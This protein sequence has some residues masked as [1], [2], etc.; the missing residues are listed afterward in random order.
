MAGWARTW[1]GRSSF[2]GSL[3]LV[4]TLIPPAPSPGIPRLS[5]P[6]LPLPFALSGVLGQAN[7]AY[8]F[9]PAGEG[10]VATSPP[11]R[12]TARVEGLV[13][14][15]VHGAEYWTSELAAWGRG[16]TLAPLTAEA[17]YA[18]DNRV[19]VAAAGVIAWVQNGPAG[20]QQGWT[21]HQPP[22][23]E[24]LLTL[25]LRHQGTLRARPEADG[26][27]LQILHADGTLALRWSGLLAWD[28]RGQPLAAGL[29][30]EG[31][32]TRLWVDAREAIYP[33]TIDP[34]VQAARLNAAGASDGS[35]LGSAVAVSADGSTIVAGAPQ[36]GC[37]SESGAV[38]V[39]LR[40]NGGWA[41]T[42]TFAAKLTPPDGVA[43][44]Q[45]GYTIALS[46][47][48]STVVVGAPFNDEAANN[49]GAAY[50][51]QRPA[52]GWS[53]PVSPTCQAHCSGEPEWR[54]VRLGGGHQWG[55][56]R[57]SRWA[58]RMLMRAGAIV[59]P[60]ISTSARIAAGLPPAPRP[61]A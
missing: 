42:A 52:G 17:P 32:F 24:G 13:L 12:L 37:S 47:D 1:V 21:V 20:V 35:V 36:C 39:F 50:I 60:F 55:M 11:H 6:P 4:S 27:G 9:Q 29:E 22:P 8:H 34:W 16:D 46:E 25:L 19:A 54:Y 41:T 2:F 53:A 15:I 7:A 33:L 10:F 3:L 57:R 45:F 51:F 58:P 56:A 23:G 30:S 59:A 43:S 61:L 14:E 38:Y 44:D 28:A 48:G 49:G 40:P 31:I 5:A 18:V 26:R